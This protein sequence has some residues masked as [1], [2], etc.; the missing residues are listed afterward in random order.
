M[1]GPQGRARRGPALRYG[2]RLLALRKWDGF[3]FT[4]SLD[5]SITVVSTQSFIH[6][7]IHPFMYSCSVIPPCAITESPSVW[8]AAIVSIQIRHK[9]ARVLYQHTDA[10]CKSDWLILR[11]FAFFCFFSTLLEKTVAIS[12]KSAYLDSYN[13]F[14]YMMDG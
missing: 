2:M 11:P 9:P 12:S 3:F 1:R 7:F 13:P 5:H 14:R 4:P 6:A 8:T 10:R